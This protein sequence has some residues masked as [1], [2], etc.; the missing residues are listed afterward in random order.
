MEFNGFMIMAIDLQAKNSTAVT[1]EK[2]P[3]YSV[4]VSPAPPAYCPHTI[5]NLN[6]TPF[7]HHGTST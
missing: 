2:R 5:A 3:G 7:I 1:A 6:E 4:G